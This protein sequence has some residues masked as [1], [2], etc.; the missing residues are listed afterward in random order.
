MT[1]VQSAATLYPFI[2]FK[3]DSRWAA[4][5]DELRAGPK[6]IGLDTEFF[7]KP[8]LRRLAESLG[9]DVR[10]KDVGKFDSWSTSLRLLQIGLPSGLV[11]IFDFGARFDAARYEGELP[12]LGHLLA[13]RTCAKI[14]V[15]L[16]TEA[17]ILRR[18]FGWKIRRGRDVMLASQVIWAGVGSRRNYMTR[19]GLRTSEPM[20]HSYQAA[21]ERVGVEIDKTEQFSDWSAE[22]L[23]PEQYNYAALDVHRDTLIEVWSR[24][25]KLAH[26]G[27]V[28]DS[29][30]VECEAAPAFWECEW[31]GTPLDAEVCRSLIADY[32]RVGD[33]LRQQCR[34]ALG[35]ELEGDGSQS[36][37]ALALSRRV[38]RALYYWKRGTGETG[39][40]RAGEELTPEQA[41]RPELPKPR[42]PK[43]PKMPVEPR[44]TAPP[45]SLSPKRRTAYELKLEVHRRAMSAY[46]VELEAYRA[47]QAQYASDLAD[48]EMAKRR[49]N[50]H[51]IP[52]M[53]EKF[54][55]EFDEDPIVS[56]LLESRSCRSTEQKL[57]K[58]LRNSWA[59][60]DMAASV[61]PIHA[62]D[63]RLA[64][65]CR[66]W[67][68]AGGFD[69]AR[70]AADSGGAGMGRSSSSKPLNNQNE[71]SL[72]LGKRRHDELKLPN[73]RTCVKPRPGRSM[74]VGD[75][76]QAH[77]RFAA[78]V[79]QD[80]ALCEDFRAGRD[81]HIRLAREFA[82]A[83]GQGD[84]FA[85]DADRR[86]ALLLMDFAAWCE[87]YQ[88]GKKNP[89]FYLI[90]ELRRPAKTG[91]YTELNLGSPDRLRQAAE[92]D[93]EPLH[94]PATI[95]VT[96]I[97]G[98]VSR[99]DPWLV[100]QMRWRE[101]NAVLYQFQRDT[102]KSANRKRTVFPFTA[103]EYGEVWSADHKR[104]L[105]LLKE[106]NIPQWAESEDDGRYSVKGTDCVSAVWMMS[107]ANALKIACTLV[108]EAFDAHPEWEA[109]IFNIVHDEI[110]AE[111][112]KEHELAVARCVFDSMQEGLRRAGL[113]SIPTCAPDDTPEKLIVSCWADK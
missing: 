99:V 88:T 6:F 32:R 63:A 75:F 14:G 3:G 85:P 69:A 64:T 48:W 35:C 42:A 7:E 78:E 108:M 82:L 51:L 70:D 65:R 79:S 44:T 39:E 110:N 76:S 20:S 43:A 93:P 47:A 106:W 30:I 91:N 18:H 9:R 104:R 57:E 50:W 25:G 60:R 90:K 12:I 66:Y 72:P 17:L 38:G 11:M 102:I 28:L 1:A 52:Q 40:I 113:R 33:D 107:E 59:L 62:D 101:V 73:A 4:C 54:L 36:A 23:T 10:E 21:A 92:T 13:S 41:K 45:E 68:I 34:D 15:S 77:M 31:R 61:N 86:A 27:G 55:A 94:L 5:V 111:C 46:A 58:R 74:I 96:D 95:E 97:H 109:F 105:Y 71:T 37:L 83:L 2:V 8:E 26:D 103:G 80:P 89:F 53:G 16:S 112:A 87:A 24:L 19:A 22:T 49:P 84:P 100:I 56:A 98:K 81:A 29:V 67:Q